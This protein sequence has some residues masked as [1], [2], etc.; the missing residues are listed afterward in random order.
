MPFTFSPRII[1]IVVAIAI[2]TGALAYFGHVKYTKGQEDTEHKY[3]EINKKLDDMK[4][5]LK[6]EML[7]IAN[8]NNTDLL[9][10]IDT[11]KTDSNVQ[12]ETIIQTIAA[13]PHM[14]S[15]TCRIPAD[16]V[17]TLNAAVT[18]TTP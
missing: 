4:S 10:R 16:I 2:M 17:K 9:A 6:V 11:I 12:R 13:N 8:R 1:V 5:E 3:A 18:E 14:E 15:D 7:T